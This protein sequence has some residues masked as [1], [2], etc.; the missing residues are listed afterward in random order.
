MSNLKTDEQMELARALNMAREQAEL[1]GDDVYRWKWILVALHNAARASIVCAVSGSHKLGALRP[2]IQDRW[3][4]AYYSG[5]QDFPEEGLDDFMALYERVKDD[6]EFAPSSDVDDDVRRLN[7]LRNDF[8]HFVPKSWMI[9]VSG[10]PRI[11]KNALS[12]VGHVAWD[13]RW[14]RWL[15]A[16]LRESAHADWSRLIEVLDELEAAY[17]A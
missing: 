17:V 15:E 5:Q 8:I 3:L 10:L 14:I 13:Q 9:E 2:R 1:V 7:Y 6:C 11:G 16:D 12:V 4:A